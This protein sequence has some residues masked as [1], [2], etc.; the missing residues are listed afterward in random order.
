MPKTDQ[1]EGETV[2]FKREWTTR[3]LE[4]RLLERTGRTWDAIP[5]S[6]DLDEADRATLDRF[7]HLA[8]DRLPPMRDDDSPEL[9]L[10]NLNLLR[11]GALTNAGLLLFGEAPQR[12]FPRASTKL[13]RFEQ[14]ELVQSRLY[15]GNLF[16]QL[17]SVLGGLRDFVGREYRFAEGGRG[18]ESRT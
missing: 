13:G 18:L 17:E 1:R 8:G 3:A 9:I 4:D 7:I 12:M 14:G 10:D 5:A 15:E 2:E 16:A 6:A 11:E